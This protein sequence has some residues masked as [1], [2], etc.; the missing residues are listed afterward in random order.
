MGIGLGLAAAL[1]WG[2]ADYYAAMSS[3]QTGALRVVLGFHAVAVAVLGVAVLAS[4]D[5][6]AG[7]SGGDAAWLVFVGALG[8]LSYLAF[9]RALAI[10]PISIVSPVVSAYAAVTV[11]CAVLISGERL[12]GSEIA[13]VAVSIVGVMLAS[14]DLAQIRTVERVAAVAVALALVT[15]VAI[16]AFVFGVAYFAEDHGWLVPLFLARAFTAVL[17]A[18]TAL[19]GDGWSF[20]HR[21]P[22]LVWSIGLIA[23][24]DTSG[25]VAF[26]FGIRHTDTSVVATAS[27]PYAVVPIALG[28]LLLH[29]RPTPTQWAGAGLVIGGL[30]LLGLAQ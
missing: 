10:G 28:V 14:S 24:L 19:A 3:R 9:Y 22:R 2:L 6:L 11:V 17:V 23:V 15:A 5:G 27:A 1:S 25:Y 20:P 4:G 12:S 16:G 30:V 18:L 29:E 7:L 21:S 26:N 8:W 13:A